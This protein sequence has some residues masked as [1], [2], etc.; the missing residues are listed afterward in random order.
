[1]TLYF[2]YYVIFVNLK[3]INGVDDRGSSIGTTGNV[4]AATEAGNLCLQYVRQSDRAHCAG[5]MEFVG[6]NESHVWPYTGK[7]SI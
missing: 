3:I 5:S 7:L 2:L 6:W 4:I 1:M